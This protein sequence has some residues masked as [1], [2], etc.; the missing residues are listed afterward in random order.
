MRFRPGSPEKNIS[1]LLS[2]LQVVQCAPG[3][4]MLSPM[5]GW[6]LVINLSLGH[7]HQYSCKITPNRLH[8]YTKLDFIHAMVCHWFPVLRSVVSSQSGVS[9]CV[10]YTS[11]GKVLSQNLEHFL[12]VKLWTKVLQSSRPKTGFSIIS[13]IAGLKLKLTRRYQEGHFKLIKETISQEDILS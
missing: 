3:S 11:P 2:C 6:T 9:R 1:S 10:S 7:L 13:D 12:T 4:Q 8:W 5:L